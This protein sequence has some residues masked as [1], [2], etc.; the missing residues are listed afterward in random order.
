[1]ETRDAKD[2]FILFN[3]TR[4]LWWQE[5]SISL[6]K[7]KDYAEPFPA[8]KFLACGVQFCCDTLWL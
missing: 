8:C 5:G 4:E 1:M 3:L 2:L 7:I 6:F